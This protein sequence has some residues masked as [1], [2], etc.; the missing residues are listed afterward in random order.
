MPKD[1]KKEAKP[2][3]QADGSKAKETT[4]LNTHK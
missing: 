4:H 3:H 1:Q 2:K